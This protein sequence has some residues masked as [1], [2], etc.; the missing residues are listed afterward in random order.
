MSMDYGHLTRVLGRPALGPAV[1]RSSG[2]VV[3]A[4]AITWHRYLKRRIEF[5]G[6]AGTLQRGQCGCDP[7]MIWSLT[8][9]CC[10]CSPRISWHCGSNCCSFC[11]DA[12]LVGRFL[13]RRSR[14]LVEGTN[15]WRAYQSHI[16]N[17]PSLLVQSAAPRFPNNEQTY[18]VFK[19]DLHNRIRIFPVPVLD[20]RT[21]RALSFEIP[22]EIKSP[23]VET[24]SRHCHQVASSVRSCNS[25]S[26]SISLL[27]VRTERYCGCRLRFFF[28]KYLCFACF[29]FTRIYVFWIS[30]FTF[31]L[32]LSRYK[33][34]CCRQSFGLSRWR[35]VISIFSYLRIRDSDNNFLPFTVT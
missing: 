16:V 32:L 28:F 2:M 14:S 20:D 17:C 30:I 25:I 26:I 8:T 23:L 5:S 11:C 13:R 22:I 3:T 33:Y 21:F 29:G 12:L 4:H 35:W 6:R 18:L 10:G 7:C 31:S 27:P 24:A 15:S 19:N 34:F 9:Y 1:L